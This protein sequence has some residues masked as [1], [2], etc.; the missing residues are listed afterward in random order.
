VSGR[1]SL[2]RCGTSRSG[3][4]RWRSVDELIG[5]GLGRRVVQAD[6]GYGDITAFR[7]GLEER[8][9]EYV[10]QV[11]GRDLGPAGR[12]GPGRARLP[13][14]RAS[15]HGSLSPTSHVG[16]KDLVLA[17]GRAHLHTI[18]WREGDRG[19]LKKPV[20]RDPGSPGQ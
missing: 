10:V 8:E 15:A 16:L 20:P 1:G 2:K 4:S 19:R 3:S 5:W 14:A 18:G 9:L 13:R 7:V 6:G 11:K 17:A 12:R